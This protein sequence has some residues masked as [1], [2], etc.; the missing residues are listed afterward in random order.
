MHVSLLGVIRN[1]LLFLRNTVGCINNPYATYRRLADEKG[2][3][4]HSTFIF[5]FSIIYFLFASLV[6][7]GKANPFLLTIQFNTLFLGG[8]LGFLTIV[9]SLF[10]LGKLVGGKGNI[11]SVFTLWSYTLLPTLVWFFTTSFL[12]IILPPPRTTSLSGKVYSVVFFSFSLA[13]F[14]WKVILYY[15]TLRFGL[16]IDLFRILFISLVIVLE[17]V[18]FSL[19]MYRLAIFRIPFL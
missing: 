1:F 3:Q 5:L 15:L 16:R 13:L 4:W 7:I 17:M 8:V 18:L 2:R 12:Y 10:L 14:F 6:R 11:Q 9:L 19:F